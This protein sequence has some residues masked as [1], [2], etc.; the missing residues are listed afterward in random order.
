MRH[1]AR[2]QLQLPR[3]P[4][5][6]CDKVW[7]ADRRTASELY[8][9]VVNVTGRQNPVRFYEHSGGWHWTSDVDGVRKPTGT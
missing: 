5:E 3:C 2:T 8:R 6:Y 9:A 4:D 1:G 7:A